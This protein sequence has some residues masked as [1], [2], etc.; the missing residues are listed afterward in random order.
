MKRTAAEVG[1]A[2]LE[3]FASANAARHAQ[4]TALREAIRHVL[5]AGKG[6]L[7]LSAKHVLRRLNLAALGRARPPSIRAVQWHIREL[8]RNASALRKRT[9]HTESHDVPSFDK[10]TC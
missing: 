8:A 6:E 7:P 1:A 10:R 2:V 5:E 4:G 3:R 9:H